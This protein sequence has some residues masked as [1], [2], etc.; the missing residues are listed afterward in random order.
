MFRVPSVHVSI[1]C[2]PRHGLIV[3]MGLMTVLL[4]P[5]EARGQDPSSPGTEAAIVPVDDVRRAVADLEG[6]VEVLRATTA[7]FR[8]VEVAL[9]E[10]YV[11]DPLNLCVSAST[12]GLPRQL[13]AMG[14]HFFRPDLLGLT[15]TEPRVNGTGTHVDFDTPA[16]LVYFPNEDGELRL[17]AIENVVFTDAWRESNG[18]ALPSYRG[19]QYYSMTDN[20]LTPMVDE[21][22]GF[23]PHYELHLWVHHEN[24]LGVASP[25]N[26]DVSC[27]TYDGPRTMEEGFRWMAEHAPQPSG[28]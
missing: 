25:F 7:R 12:E 16:V 27:A 21:A 1:Q 23:E 4:A 14:V 15:A 2:Q 6:R 19:I 20:P 11:R 8:D 22:H 3:A 5:Q 24:P 28:R 10:G 26:P 18:T 17:G 13:G 9:A